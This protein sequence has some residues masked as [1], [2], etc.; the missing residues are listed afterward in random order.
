MK[1]NELIPPKASEERSGGRLGRQEAG[2][3]V[4]GVLIRGGKGECYF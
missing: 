1:G 2:D 4:V 3:G